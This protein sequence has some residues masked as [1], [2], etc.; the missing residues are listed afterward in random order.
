[1][2]NLDMR[3]LFLQSYKIVRPAEIQELS[4]ICRPH[5]LLVKDI[6]SQRCLTYLLKITQ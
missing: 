3:Y 5:E 6:I 2:V 4:T 1:M